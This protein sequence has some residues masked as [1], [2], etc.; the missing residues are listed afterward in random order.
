MALHLAPLSQLS[1]CLIHL[2][3]V[4]VSGS[5]IRGRMLIL[6]LWVLDS[7]MHENCSRKLVKVMMRVCDSIF[8]MQT[9]Y[10]SICCLVFQGLVFFLVAKEKYIKFYLCILWNSMNNG[11]P[12][13]IIAKEI[14]R[15][16]ILQG[17]GFCGRTK[18]CL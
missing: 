17:G 11:W 1:G 5:G 3:L 2:P 15:K 12:G 8:L 9:F 4:G 16:E 13:V 14:D 18:T 6:G 10:L 7:H